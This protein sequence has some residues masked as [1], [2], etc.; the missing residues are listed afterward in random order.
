MTDRQ[1]VVLV[2][3]WAAILAVAA[4]TV[5]RLA[6]DN[7][8]GWFAYGPNTGAAIV[9][10][11]TEIIWREALVWLG[12]VAVWAVPSLWLLRRRDRSD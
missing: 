5:N 8:G 12:A 2:V 3:A 11:R 1:R 10:D 6:L 4:M 9:P 7:D